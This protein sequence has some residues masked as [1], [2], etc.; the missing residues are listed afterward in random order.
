MS[1]NNK[2]L[3]CFKI[4]LY[5]ICTYKTIIIKI[6]PWLFKGKLNEIRDDFIIK[7]NTRKI[8]MTAGQQNKIIIF[9][10]RF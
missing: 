6:C 3:T 9:Y 7:N 2:F 1:Y 10:L 5:N 4:T 8:T